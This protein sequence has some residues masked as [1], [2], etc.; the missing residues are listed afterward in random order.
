ML[1]KSCPALARA[2]SSAT[3]GEQQSCP[4]TGAGRPAGRQAEQRPAQ[5]LRS[6]PGDLER[7]TRNFLVHRGSVVTPAS[8]GSAVASR[9]SSCSATCR[10][11]CS[12]RLSGSE[13]AA[14][15][16]RWEELLGDL[17]E[18]LQ[19]PAQRLGAGPGDL[20]VAAAARRPAGDPAA[21][22]SAARRG[23]R[24][25][26]EVGAAARRPAGAAAGDRAAPADREVPTRAG[27]C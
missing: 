19:R 24:A 16:S 25:T 4:A 26:I 15:P 14:R 17:P 27:P 11:S 13:R 21:T 5:R 23:G 18:I 6:G 7:C 9:I 20:R 2:S 1:D 10:R 12:D 3:S 8:I 22:G